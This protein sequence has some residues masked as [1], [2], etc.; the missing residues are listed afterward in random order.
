MKNFLVCVVWALALFAGVASAAPVKEPPVFKQ[1]NFK[2]I[3]SVQGPSGLTVWTVE[4]PVPGGAPVR[5]VLMTTPDGATL[6]S[7]VV[8]DAASGRNLSDQFLSSAGVVAPI[9]TPVAVGA[10]PAQAA[11]QLP[12]SADGVPLAIKDI[13]KLSG[14]KEGKD[15]P[16]GTLYVIFDPQCPHCHNLYK[17]SRQF[18]ANGLSIKWIPVAVVGGTRD[19]KRLVAEFMQASK[20]QDAFKRVMSDENYIPSASP[21]ASTLEQLQEN[22]QY[23]FAAFRRNPG[24]GQPVVPVVFF[25]TKQ[26]QP[27]MVAGVEDVPMLTQIRGDM[28]K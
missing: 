27:Q 11:A 20:P 21:N 18:V 9:P 14:I 10:G 12:V 4:R 1:L 3:G 17:A 5:T 24:A 2:V 28:K 19:G 23:L 22:T 13:E 16:L 7:G 26:G 6:I 8:W 15:S 25:V